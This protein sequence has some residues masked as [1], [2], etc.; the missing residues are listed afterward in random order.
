[1]VA[2]RGRTGS[3]RPQPR[4]APA[5]DDEHRPPR[6]PDGAPLRGNRDFHLLFAAAAASKLGTQISYLAIPLLAVTTLDAS[7]AQ[8]GLLGTLSTVSFLAIG[9]PAGVWVDRLRRRRLQIL[10]DLTRMVLLASVPVTWWLGWLSMELL[11]AVV[12]AVGVGTVFF[13]VAAQ[14]YLPQIVGRDGLVVANARLASADAVSQVAGRSVGGFVVQLLTAPVALLVDATSYLWSAL[15]LLRI[16]DPDARPP[17]RPDRHLAREIGQGIRF[18]LGHPLLRPLAAAG[19]V[20]NLSVQLTVT[21]MPLVFVRELGL[22]AGALGLYLAVGGAGVLVGS[23]NA[24]RV[25]RW[26]GYGRAMWIVGLVSAPAKLVIPL[27]DRGPLLWLAA[28]GWLLTTVQV[29]INNVLQVS[30]RQ[31]VTPDGLLGRMNATMRFLLT[32]AVALGAAAAGLLGEVAGLRFALWV[33]A[34][35]LAL[36]WVPAYLSPIR[37]M[38]DLPP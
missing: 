15:C 6:P 14:S 1:M 23:L 29:G 12:L 21:L 37:R 5:P 25:A 24:N 30:L 26:L 28:G 27:I 18:V 22:S 19:A 16:R 36:V 33:G 31:R 17:A 11:Y 2:E 9:L 10:A 8:V 3:P 38:R 20:T 34:V 13:D 4:P 32:G 7:P 35:G